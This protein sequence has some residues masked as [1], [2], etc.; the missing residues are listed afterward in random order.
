[1]NKLVLTLCTWVVLCEGFSLK[2][3][4]LC[5]NL[6]TNYARNNKE[7]KEFQPPIANFSIEDKEL[8]FNVISFCCKKQLR[9]MQCDS[10]KE[11][12]KTSSC[13]KQEGERRDCCEACLFGI[14]AKKSGDLCID[15]VGLGPAYSD[16][17]TTC[18]EEIILPQVTTT[19]TTV[20]PVF[21]STPNTLISSILP[22]N[23]D[24]IYPG[25]SEENVCETGEYCAQLCEPS[26]KSF[27]CKCFSGYELMKDGVSC[28]PIKRA[29]GRR[30]EKNN[31]CDQDCIDTGTAIECSCRKG[32]ELHTDKKSCKDIDECAL[33]IHECT[34]NEIC[35]N[36]DGTYFCFSTNLDGE[37]DANRCPI[38]HRFNA[39]T[40][41]C[42]DIDECELPL[43]CPSPMICK[44]SIGSF[45][46]EGPNCPPGFQY[47]TSI[48]ACTD[49]DECLSPEN[50]CN[51]DS[52]LC[53]NTKGNY[54]CVEKSSRKICPAG[55][56]TNNETF[57]CEDINE[58]EESLEV[59]KSNEKCINEEG[60]YRCVESKQDERLIFNTNVGPVTLSK[61]PE[62]LQYNA[63]TNTC[64]DVNECQ[65][66]IDN[67]SPM[68]RCDNTV[69]SFY[70]TRVV[71][72]GTGYTLNSAKDLCEDDDECALGTHNC[73]GLGSNFACK[74]QMGTYKCEPIRPLLFPSS[75][76]STTT[77]STTTTT[78]VPSTTS[79]TTST[80]MPPHTSTLKPIPI[81]NI[82]GDPFYPSNRRPWWTYTTPKPISRAPEVVPVFSPISPYVPYSALH[83]PASSIT[84][85]LPIINGMLKKC[86]PGYRMDANGHC[87]DIDECENNPCPRGSKCLNFNGRFQ[88]S[89]PLHCKIGYEMNETGDQCID[90]DECTKGNHNCNKSQICKN[91]QG[92]Y[93]CECP[94]GH[95]LNRHTQVC[96]DLDEC[97]FYRPCGNYAEC[98]NTVGSFHCSCQSGFKMN[99]NYCEEINECEEIQGL[100]EH[101][102]INVW[103]SHRCGC[104]PGFVL[105]ADNR[106]CTDI[107]ECEMFADRRLCIG[108]CVNIPGSYTCECPRGYKLGTDKRGC[109]DIDE[110]QHNV[111]PPE[112]ACVNTR[113]GYKCYPIS[114]SA[115]YAKDSNHKARCRRL[116]CSRDAQC[117]SK[118]DQYSYQ[119]MALVSKLPLPMEGIPLFKIK[120]PDRTAARAEFSMKFL[121]IICP[122]RENCVD[123]TFVK[124][125]VHS[126]SN[127]MEL[128]LV[129]SIIGP[130]EVKLE[131]QMQL[132]QGVNNYIGN[133]I[134]YIIIVVSE[135]TF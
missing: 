84:T 88:C 42:D 14:E 100:C 34:T 23:N 27:R 52:Q 134:V 30:C 3:R 15:A 119:F 11:D 36:D 133:V 62:G 125:M 5:C 61:C 22:K 43:I 82:W 25:L 64:D 86:L 132:F 99:Q 37:E 63:E 75:G 29:K 93:T 120:G 95:H 102:C 33:G 35:E 32:Y 101:N 57:H 19:S 17:F 80:S 71:S 116:A 6:G 28:R 126:D 48:E 50:R 131:V 114:C 7:C 129:K 97:K 89:T 124:K 16:V 123:D 10:G 108:N 76:I 9:S 46:C 112:D 104:Q 56:K 26:G 74:N 85:T 78:P 60:G 113:G 121:D 65:L 54:T 72:C 24:D 79:S 45:M 90:V 4:Q 2:T 87:E 115:G 47:K 103:G 59:C 31:P 106:T 20:K 55:F 110:C 105:R 38:G 39:E 91:G 53:V 51:K 98:T 44:N 122:H 73:G 117:L 12:A 68:H 21:I 66:R 1:M 67:C 58:C 135:Y 40:S 83:K 118:P 49:I 111:C 96:E 77:K 41:V 8:C 127:F 70:C 109:I 92:Y 69:G 81:T 128:I 94:V 13:I 107:N 18:C 130:Q